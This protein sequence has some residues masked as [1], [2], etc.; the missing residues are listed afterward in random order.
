[1]WINCFHHCTGGRFQFACEHVDICLYCCVG[2]DM[3]AI[4]Y[5]SLFWRYISKFLSGQML[6]W[7]LLNGAFQ[8]FKKV[9]KNKGSEFKNVLYHF[10]P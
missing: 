2:A 4:N 1:M 8:L 3:P 9:K 10:F 6:S 5:D 7:H